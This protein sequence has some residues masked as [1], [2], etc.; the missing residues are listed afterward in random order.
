MGDFSGT[1]DKLFTSKG[2]EKNLGTTI[3]EAGFATTYGRVPAN[4]SETDNVQ[5]ILDGFTEVIRK[6]RLDAK[7]FF[8]DWDRHKRFKVTQKQFT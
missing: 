3:G 4:Y 5:R 2:L 6:K 1:I 7:S 8:Q